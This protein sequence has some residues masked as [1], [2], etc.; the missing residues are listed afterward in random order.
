MTL[1]ARHLTYPASSTKQQSLSVPLGGHLLHKTPLVPGAARPQARC[2]LTREKGA[3]Q[4]GKDGH[5]RSPQA[6]CSMKIAL[7]IPEM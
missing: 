5:K 1:V 3:V 6:S 2:R 7:E 4:A